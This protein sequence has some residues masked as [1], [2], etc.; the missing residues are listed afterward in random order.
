MHSKA[1]FSSLTLNAPAIRCYA[2]QACL[3]WS[4]YDPPLVTLNKKE[5]GLYNPGSITNILFETKLKPIP[6]I[7]VS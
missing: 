6:T 4:V 7:M 3:Y 5:P 2:S 1:P